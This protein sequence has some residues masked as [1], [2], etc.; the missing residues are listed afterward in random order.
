MKKFEIT[1]NASFTVE[2]EDEEEAKQE[3]L[4][5]YMLDKHDLEVDEVEDEWARLRKARGRSRCHLQR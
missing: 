3:V 2:A 5:N 1:I 4:I